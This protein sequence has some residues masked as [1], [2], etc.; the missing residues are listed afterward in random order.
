MTYSELVKHNGASIA[1]TALEQRARRM[2]RKQ[3][4]F[5]T[6]ISPRSRWYNQYG[7]FMISDLYTRV[8]EACCLES[9]EEVINYLGEEHDTLSEVRKFTETTEAK[10]ELTEAINDKASV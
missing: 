5:I 7:A 10:A 6:K 9:I 4:K 8:V 3:D 2:A 1:E